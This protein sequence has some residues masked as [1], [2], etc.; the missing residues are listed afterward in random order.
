MP[1]I[2]ARSCLSSPAVLAL[3]ALPW[4]CGPAAAASRIVYSGTLQGA[5]EVVMELD[6]QPADGV[7]KGRYFYPRHGVD[8]PLQGTPQALAEPM[9]HQAAVDTGWNPQ[10][11][12]PPAAATW[13]G[14]RDAQG[15]RGTWTDARSG[16]TRGFS[17]KRVAE[18]DPEQTAPGA[19]QAVTEAIS[20]GR[21]S[22]VDAGADINARSAP[23]ETLKLAGHAVP[24]G[25]EVGAGAAAYR[26]WR[27]PRTGFVY[28]R[29]ARHPNAQTLQRVNHLLEQ[30]HWQMSLAALA[31]KASVYENGSW[32]AGTLGGYDEE[33]VQV[34]WLSSALLTVTESGSLFCGGAHPDN[35]FDL[36][37]YDLLRGEYLDWNRVFPAYVAGEYSQSA[38]SP[39]LLKIVDRARQKMAAAARSQRGRQDVDREGC[40]DVW[41]EFLALGAQAPGALSLSVSGV[42]HAMGVCLGTYAAVPFKDLEPYLAPGGRAYLVK[43]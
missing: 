5:G 15:Y 22:G 35:H 2:R 36:Y 24:A 18:Y 27:D 12:P 4:L 26:M 17:L 40:S 14:E 39:A 33:S 31:C 41:P 19:V 28:P 30:R 34:T 10:A 43:D 32:G 7:V 42:G 3:A 11:S 29:L 1:V 20:G 9:T 38:P 25:E 8:I 23:Y 16:K 13:K 6:S 37:T 21:G